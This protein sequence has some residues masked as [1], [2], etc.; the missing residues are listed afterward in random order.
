MKKFLLAA[1]MIAAVSSCSKNETVDKGGNKD[2][3]NQINL[4]TGVA[5]TKA[6]FTPNSGVSEL[7]FLLKTGSNM[8]TS[9]AGPDVKLAVGDRAADAEGKITFATA[10][11]HDATLNTYIASYYPAGTVT[12]DVVAWNV[13]GKVDIMTAAAV[14]AGT[15]A[16]AAVGTPSAMLDYK[17]ALAQ[18]VVSCQAEATKATEVQARWG[19]V[20]GVSISNSASRFTYSYATQATAPFVGSEADIAL[21]AADYTASFAPLTLVETPAADLSA[22]GMFAPS[23]SNFITL[24]VDITGGTEGTT[25]KTVVVDLGAG[26]SFE[27]AKTHV[28]TL[29]FKEKPTEKEIEVKSSIEAWGTGA[30]GSADVD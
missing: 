30:T 23:T 14:D 17:H 20:T 3:L 11:Y 16:A 4:S 1:M 10:Q 2:G 25:R 26:K 8:P 9:F 24:K 22:A 5:G 19:K 13:N 6:A 7:Q 27:R 29:T 12:N 28:I 18:L 21:S 15:N